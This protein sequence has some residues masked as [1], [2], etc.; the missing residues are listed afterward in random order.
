MLRQL[1]IFL[2]ASF[3]SLSTLQGPPREAHYQAPEDDIQLTPIL[4]TPNDLTNLAIPYKIKGNANQEQLEWCEN[5]LAKTLNSLKANHVQEIQNLTLSFDPTIRRG[6]GGGHTM[7]IR[8]VNI[9]EQEMAAVVVHELGHIVDTGLLSSKKNKQQSQFDDRGNPVYS[10]DPSIQFYKISWLNSSS[11]KSNSPVSNFISGY[12]QELPQEDFAESYAAYI[13]HGR[14][15][16]FYAAHNEEVAKKY[17]FLRDV[18]FKGQE[19]QLQ[20]SLP[21]ILEIKN[22]VYDVTRLDFDLQSFWTLS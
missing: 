18:V 1:L 3:I 13:L 17:I 15:F 22:R 5:I 10:D 4:K 9:D 19:Y 16:R 14:L 20:E 11:L 12:S 2:L 8:C 6:L 21:K 7:V